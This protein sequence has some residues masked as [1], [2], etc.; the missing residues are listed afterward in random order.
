[1]IHHHHHHHDIHINS[2]ININITYEV[3]R[4]RL[5]RDGIG[6][7]LEK[8]ETDETD[9]YLFF[10]SK[11]SLEILMIAYISSGQR[12]MSHD[13]NGEERRFER[14]MHSS[15][16]KWIMGNREIQEQA[17]SLFHSIQSPDHIK[18]G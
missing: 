13:E 8:T 5:I 11:R 14:F 17:V 1:M 15:K 12:Y 2:N 4:N 18:V 9:V 7:G 3:F 10:P 16:R 6:F